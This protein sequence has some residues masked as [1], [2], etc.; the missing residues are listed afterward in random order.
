MSFVLDNL[1]INKRFRTFL[2]RMPEIDLIIVYIP[3]ENN[4]CSSHSMVEGDQSSSTSNVGFFCPYTPVFRTDVYCIVT[5]LD[6]MISNNV[7]PKE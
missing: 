2:H 6:E 1:Y 3:R 5:K 7:L 4:Y